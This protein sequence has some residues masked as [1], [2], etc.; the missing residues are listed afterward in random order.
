M[1]DSLDAITVRR[2]LGDLAGLP[3]HRPKGESPSGLPLGARNVVL[4]EFRGYLFAA[5]G[6][7]VFVLKHINKD[8]PAHFAPLAEVPIL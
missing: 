8:V 3:S 1:T 6:C 7:E 2:D 4:C 5:V